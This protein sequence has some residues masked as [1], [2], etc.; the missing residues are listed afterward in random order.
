M[1]DLP[2]VIEEYDPK[3]GKKIRN[4][5]AADNAIIGRAAF[6]KA[7]EYLPN[8]KIIYRH[9]ARVIGRQENL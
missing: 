9:K 3:T 1:N 8:A 2:F 4:L 6:E 7:C 5:A